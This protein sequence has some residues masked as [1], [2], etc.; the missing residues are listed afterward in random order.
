MR[1][2]LF[3]LFLGTAAL[4][5]CD[6]NPTTTCPSS[7]A[8]VTVADSVLGAGQPASGLVTVDYE[9]RLVST[10]STFDQGSNVQFNL[11]SVI[12]G[13]RQGIGGRAATDDAPAIAPMRPG[14]IRRITIPANYAYGAFPPSAAIPQCADLSFDVR[15]IDP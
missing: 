11:S 3:A 9:G 15:L 10:G 1:L 12:L 13:F 6:S 14:G 2:P 5:A 7:D 4:A 8:L